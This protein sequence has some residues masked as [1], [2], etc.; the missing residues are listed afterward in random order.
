MIC[1]DCKQEYS[2]SFTHNWICQSLQEFKR[3]ADEGGP[4]ATQELIAQAI[5]H[6]MY[7]YLPE[8][9]PNV[10]V[11]RHIRD[12]AHESDAVRYRAVV[13]LGEIGRGG[14]QSQSFAAI[15][16]LIK[17]LE[18]DS[19]S[20]MTNLFGPEQSYIR[21]E[22]A[23][24]LG[25]ISE[26]VFFIRDIIPLLKNENRHVR[27][28]AAIALRDIV[29]RW[30]PNW[31]SCDLWRQE[32]TIVIK[33]GWVPPSWGPLHYRIVIPRL[34]EALIEALKD[35]DPAVRYYAAEALGKTGDPVAVPALIDVA[36]RDVVSLSGEVGLTA[37][38]ALGEIG[39]PIAVPELI[40]ALKDE[41][42]TVRYN[43]IVAL[44]ILK[45]PAAVPALYN[46]A[47]RDTDKHTRCEAVESLGKIGNTVAVLALIKVLDAESS[48]SYDPWKDDVRI[49]AAEALG[50][51]GDSAAVPVLIDALKDVDTGIRA[52]STDKNF[53]RAVVAALVRI[54]H[55]GDLAVPMLIDALNENQPGSVSEY[56]D[57]VKNRYGGSRQCFR[58]VARILGKIG[59]PTT[60]PALTKVLEDMNC[61]P[62]SFSVWSGSSSERDALQSALKKIKEK[63]DLS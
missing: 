21:I 39:D 37:A 30:A 42:S 45:A 6:E 19:G 32:N 46:I 15:P 20:I 62:A 23:A 25:K 1:P 28:A 38:V 59:D 56:E 17:T 63:N 40:D 44:G 31:P 58:E 55:I 36:L 11:Y 9:G 34:R 13:D 16:P 14:P 24:A 7:S 52:S 47:L 12:L 57:A 41:N 22:A 51:I 8:V 49:S 33:V 60:I 35:R 27:L 10:G 5:K 61:P 54:S 53:Y 43:A 4:A 29:Y 26:S 2:D 48:S 3:L 18:K 50:E